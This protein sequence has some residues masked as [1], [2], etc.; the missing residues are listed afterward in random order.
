MAERDRP[1]IKIA[2]P[3][4]AEPYTRPPLNIPG[5]EVPVPANRRSHGTRLATELAAAE[6]EALARREAMA[7]ETARADGILI[8]F[9][10]FPGVELALE[11]LDPRQGKVHPELR[12]VRSVQTAEG[13]REQATVFIPDGKL[14]YFL[15]RLQAYAESADRERPRNRKL[16]DRIASISVASLEQLWTDAPAEFPAPQTRSWWELWLRRSDGQ[17]RERVE[18]FATRIEAQLDQRTLAFPDRLVVL[19]E[20]TAEQLATAL[21]V[22]NDLA[23]LRRPARTATLLVRE[24]PEEQ[25]AWIAEL[26]E[27]TMSSPDDAPAAC[28]LD[29]GTNA[30]HPLLA[31]SLSADDCHACDP[32]W[33]VGDHGGHGT[34]MAGLA[35]YG[36]LDEAL[37][38]TDE[39]RLSHRLESVKILPPPPASNPPQLYGAVT[40]TAT[41]LVEIQRPARPRVFSLA[42]T[43]DGDTATDATEPQY[44]QPTS[45]SA[46]ID[47]LAAGLEIDIEDDGLLFLNEDELAERRLFLVSAGN[48]SVWEDDHLA[49]SDVEPVADPAQAWNALT[50]GAYTDLIDASSAPGF[51]GYTPLAPRGELSPFSRTGVAFDR[52]WPHKPDIVVEGGNL[53]RSPAGTELDTPETLQLLTT[54]ALLTNQRLLT[55]TNAT[56]AATAQAAHI[57]AAILADNPMLWPETIRALIVHSA[58][59]TP[60]MRQRLDG[61]NNSRR[62]RVALLHRYGLGVPDLTRA[63]RSATD[64]LTLVV[65]E[66]IHPFDGQGRTREMHLHELPWPTEELAAI[67]EAEV[68]MRVTLSYFVEPNPARRGW[69]RR[70]SYP[71]HGL[72][73]AVRRPTETTTEFRERINLQARA[74]EERRTSTE[75]DANEWFFGPEQRTAGSLHTDIWHG[76][77]ADLAERGVLAVFPVSGWWKERKDRD[78]SERGARYALIVSIETPDQD[79]D[80]WTPVAQ[81]VGVEIDITT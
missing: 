55:V 10:S 56:S 20:A 22:L 36:S 44:G 18:R 59:W 37:L 70:Y 76:T 11:S 17:E 47:A 29:T 64:A 78:H 63:T 49:R 4:A 42:V 23:E 39:V 68:R 62:R 34:E 53:A 75:S 48:V 57:G 45:W 16:V 14:G 58:E 1:H 79:V 26:V 74:E 8:T 33:G 71:S 77:A 61:T 46:A 72:R 25:A 30:Q 12:A 24:P 60:A 41:S 32:G 81:E 9:E 50:V 21:D 7:E 51:D 5:V 19:I 27:R 69:V 15:R 28:V 73:F 2:R 65:E 40:A 80:I 6:T 35:L 54:N 43:A 52:T 67:G 38:G 3:A 66:T 13:I 31:P